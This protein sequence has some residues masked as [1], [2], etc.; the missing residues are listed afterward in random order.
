LA[1]SVGDYCREIFII[2]CPT[3]SIMENPYVIQPAEGDDFVGRKASYH[4]LERYLKEKSSII[5]VTGERGIGKTSFLR[6]LSSQEFT[7][8]NLLIVEYRTRKLGKEFG[9]PDL[10]KNLDQKTRRLRDNAKYLVKKLDNLEFKASLQGGVPSLEIG[11]SPRAFSESPGTAETNYK[12]LT[13]IQDFLKREKQKVIILVEDAHTLSEVEQKI[14]SYLISA[15]SNFFV[16]LEVPTVEKNR[17]LIRDYKPISLERLSRKEC[18]EIIQKGKFLDAEIG[19]HMYQMTEGNPYYLQSICWL[20]YE[21]Y[22]EGNFIDIPAFIDTLKGKDFKDRKDRIHREILN[23]LDENSRQLVRDLA[24]APVLITHKLITV[25][26]RNKDIDSA[27]SML[28]RKGILR[29][30]RGVFSIYHSLFREFLR[31]E[32]EHTIATE[33]EDI[34]VKAAENLKKEEDCAL[35]LNELR[36]SDILPNIV[37]IVENEQVLLDFGNEEFD[38]G[39]WKTAELCFERGV[40]VNGEYKPSFVG[41]LGI[42]FY[43]VGDFDKALRYYNETLEIDR[44]IGYKQGEASQLGNIGIIFRA[45]GDLDQAL[46]YLEDALEI[47]RKIGYKQ[48]EASQLGNIGIIFSDKGDLDQ[49]L[50]YH[51]D[52]LEIHRQIGYKQGEAN[53]LGNIGIIFRAKGDLDQA[54]KYLEDALE[55]H[56]KIGYKQG[57]ASQLGNIGI[58]FNDKGDLDQALKYLKDALEI[59][60]QIGYKQG[61]ANQLGN[62][63]LIFRA[64]GDLDQ[65]LKH[66]EDA[67]EIH[68]KIGYK[69]GEASDLGNIGL[70]FSDKGDLDQALKYLEDALEIDRKIGYKQGEANQLG[71]IGIIFRAKG[72]LDQALKYY[73]DALEIHRKIGYKQGEASDLGNIGIIFN[74]KGDLDQALKYYKDAL[75]IHRKIGYKQG[76]ASQLGNIGIIFRAKGDLD[77]ALKY[78]KDA[79]EID[80]Q[81]GYKQGEASDL[82]NIGLIF[83][84]KG[85]LDQALKYLE[86]ALEI[87]TRFRLTYGRQ[88][89]ENAIRNIKS[90]N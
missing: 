66:L 40:S 72:D 8:Q 54:L 90:E 77:Q 19:E 37:S 21:K 65:A 9:I 53:Q 81:I 44:K 29:E 73:K 84:A 12:I 82:G 22:L 83:R 18:M 23:V 59:H 86:D 50:K 57:E 30:E 32:Q 24:I 34:Y 13:D 87:L 45:K 68:R 48:G 70:I 64:K 60:R 25:F 17:I 80:R 26:S 74:D 63:G 42:I 10:C 33:L 85:D 55:I 76:E 61:E 14:F 15:C 67:L 58:I 46:K 2:Y 36:D 89:I 71:N 31:S 4:K 6:N 62:I 79:L 78:H 35:L 69:Q 43:S 49:A 20:L 16:V 52:A 28:V 27:L 7:E 39:H 51:K 41:S 5:L 47:H 1:D 11:K 3:Q 75:E 38:F 88:I 56:R